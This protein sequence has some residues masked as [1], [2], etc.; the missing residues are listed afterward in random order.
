MAG[1][2]WI[3]R[4][5]GSGRKSGISSSASKLQWS[6]TIKINKERLVGQYSWTS[7]LCESYKS[8]QN[9]VF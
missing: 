8:A 9:S 3:K 2:K 7:G 6:W 1:K 5:D 4:I